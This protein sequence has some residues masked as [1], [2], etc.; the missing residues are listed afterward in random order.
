MAPKFVS[1]KP[2]GELVGPYSSVVVNFDDL[3][4]K[5]A[6][7]VNI[8]KK[9]TT[10]PLAVYRYGGNDSKQVEIAPKASLARG[11]WYTVKV[12]T[13]ANDGA[14]KLAAAKTWNF[15]TK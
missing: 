9:G 11:T 3:V 6:P 4:Y 7:F 10:T 13:G 8:Y 1:G 15:K 14:N 12:T 5:S 2:T